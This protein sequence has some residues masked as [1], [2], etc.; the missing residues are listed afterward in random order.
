MQLLLVKCRIYLRFGVSME[1]T[2]N[3]SHRIYE[4]GGSLVDKQL[5][6]R[7]GIRMILVLLR[8]WSQMIMG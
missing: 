6:Y 7:N 8:C 1:N 3:T 4:G 2:E 5:A